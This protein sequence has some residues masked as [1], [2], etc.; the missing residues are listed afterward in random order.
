M[1]RHAFKRSPVTGEKL[2][3]AIESECLA[4]L[5]SVPGVFAWKNHTAGF[6]DPKRRIFRRHHSPWAIRG[7]SDILGV[8]RGRLIAV[9]VKAKGGRISSEQSLFIDRVREFGALACVVWSLDELREAFQQWTSA[10]PAIDVDQTNALP[11]T[12]TRPPTRQE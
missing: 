7:T 12:S 1:R 8:Y 2:E 6:F 9:E 5:N 3:I 10:P 4:W 11:Q